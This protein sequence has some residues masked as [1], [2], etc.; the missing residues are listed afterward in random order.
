MAAL[1]T[2]RYLEL[3]VSEMRAE[4]SARQQQALDRGVG[5]HGMRELVSGLESR[6]RIGESSRIL[7]E[8]RGLSASSSSV[9]HSVLYSHSQPM[10]A[11]YD[12]RRTQ[13]VGGNGEFITASWPED[14]VVRPLVSSAFIDQPSSSNV[15]G[16]S[17]LQHGY[18]SIP[19]V[20]SAPRHVSADPVD[21]MRAPF[22]DVDDAYFLSNTDL[23]PA[24]RIYEDLGYGIPSTGYFPPQE[25]N[26]FAPHS[27]GAGQVYALN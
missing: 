9:G 18:S 26:H 3:K 13:T 14:G 21:W 6:Y 22:R 27:Y 2:F 5:R 11:A 23:G 8:V 12:E 24:P 1:G 25:R 4:Q 19:L 16:N 10:S 15:G 17:Y 20:S 7:Q